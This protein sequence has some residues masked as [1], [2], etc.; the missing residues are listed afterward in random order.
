M[1]K[2]E[3]YIGA[4]SGVM[5]FLT[6]VAD[7][8]ALNVLTLIMCVPIFT[9]GASLTAMYT[10]TGRMVRGDHYYLFKGF[11]KAFKEN[12]K[13]ATAE[14]LMLLGVYLFMALDIYI[15]IVNETTIPRIVLYLLIA[16]L[17]LIF[18]EAQFL[19]PIQSRFINP[20]KQTIKMTA[21]M[22]TA[23]GLRKMS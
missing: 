4:G 17:I 13:Q 2:F 1:G 5:S 23:S 14:W 3:K 19:F 21:M 22:A 6:K 11:F 7:L 10:I 9:I 16:M 12:F 18:I 15:M 8:I 20:V